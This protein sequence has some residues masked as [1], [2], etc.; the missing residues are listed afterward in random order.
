MWWRNALKEAGSWEGEDSG[1]DLP[2]KAKVEI[3][4]SGADAH[5]SKESDTDVGEEQGEGEET[6]TSP[7]AREPLC[8]TEELGS[9]QW[10]S[11]REP[12]S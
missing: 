9:N 7:A 12:T 1:K 4:A 5:Q 3:Q 11:N 8:D 2:Q 6:T 10:G